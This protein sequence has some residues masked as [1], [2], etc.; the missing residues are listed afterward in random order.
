MRRLLLPSL[1]FVGLALPGCASENGSPTAD[2]AHKPAGDPP[3]LATSPEP[4]VDAKLDAYNQNLP[5]R[6]DMLP[7]IMGRT[8]DGTEITNATLKGK[9][10]LIN[11]WFYH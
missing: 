11:L 6:G 7:T 4:I 2:Q 1:L 3:T 10:T 9:T 5:K 8:L